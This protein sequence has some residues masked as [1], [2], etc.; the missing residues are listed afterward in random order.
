MRSSCF[1]GEDIQKRGKQKIQRNKPTGT[2]NIEVDE[3]QTYTVN[4][5]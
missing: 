4:Y 5:D 1:I 2:T 3:M